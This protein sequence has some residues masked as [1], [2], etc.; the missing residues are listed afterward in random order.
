MVAQLT[1]AFTA[2]SS[3]RVLCQ[4]TVFAITCVRV[5]PQE[6]IWVVVVG[7]VERYVAILRVH[8]NCCFFVMSST[9]SLDVCVCVL[10]F[11]KQKRARL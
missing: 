10:V 1:H 2:K 3:T 8:W 6:Q 5:P 11:L 4:R 9:F 7:L